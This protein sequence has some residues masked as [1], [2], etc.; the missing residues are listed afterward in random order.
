M[1]NVATSSKS[2]GHVQKK[3]FLIQCRRTAAIQTILDQ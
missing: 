1:I 2:L 3:N